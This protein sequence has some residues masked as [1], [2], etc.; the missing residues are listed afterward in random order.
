MINYKKIIF[1]ISMLLMCA[2]PLL[3]QNTVSGIVVDQDGQPIPGVNILDGNDQTN[4]TVTDFEGNFTI[5][6]R[7]SVV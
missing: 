5:R 3:A 2:N 1:L 7:K 6:D 4:G